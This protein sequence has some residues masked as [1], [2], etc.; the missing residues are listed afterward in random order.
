MNDNTK[1]WRSTTTTHSWTTT[2]DLK[3]GQRADIE[4]LLANATEAASVSEIWRY[5]GTENGE[6][7]QVEIKNGAVTVNGQRYDSLEAVP[8][9]QRERIEALRSGQDNSDVWQL[10]R[11]AGIDAEGL[12]PAMREQAAKPEFTMDTE[13]PDPAQAPAA[14]TRAADAVNDA[15]LAP[16]AVPAG[17]GLR[18]MLLIGI[19][20]G[21]GWWGARALNLF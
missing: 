17:G 3:P 10:L 4:T 14:Q 21:L 9:A 16:G 12:A 11:E 2:K 8:R 5:A 19:A 18:R 7:F 15:S 6:T 13:G 20:V 1:T